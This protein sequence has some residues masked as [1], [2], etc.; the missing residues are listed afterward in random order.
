MYEFNYHLLEHLDEVTGIARSR[1]GLM[2]GKSK[3]FMRHVVLESCDIKMG[4]LME[5]CDALR[6]PIGN[7]FYLEGTEPVREVAATYDYKPAK[8]DM[9]ILGELLRGEKSRYEV[10]LYKIMNAAGNADCRNRRWTKD[11]RHITA[12]DLV[13]LCNG[14]RLGMHRI[15][16]CPMKSV[17]S[18]FTIK[19]L[20]DRCTELCKERIRY[21]EK[22]GNAYVPKYRAARKERQMQAEAT[23]TSAVTLESIQQ[24]LIEIK[25][26]QQEIKLQLE[27]LRSKNH[28]I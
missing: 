10:P 1:I 17:P 19:Q 18:A 16:T 6:I 7:F 14:M 25:Q 11:I 26:E 3:D 21:D 5:M 2:S 12:R 8:F 20:E 9:T 27:A 4:D 15:V 13:K 28:S 23:E 24:M 22:Y